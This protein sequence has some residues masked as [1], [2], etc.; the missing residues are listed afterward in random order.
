M[1]KGYQYWYIYL[2]QKTSA[3]IAAECIGGP[4]P[5]SVIITIEQIHKPQ[6]HKNIFK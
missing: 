2:I 3:T 1:L 6:L 5:K 4:V